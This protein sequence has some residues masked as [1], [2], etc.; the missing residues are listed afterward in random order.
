MSAIVW[1]T[2]T[3]TSSSLA[4][5]LDDEIR[6]S[7]ATI[8]AGLG[9]SFYG[10]GSAA[11]QGASTASSGEL[12]LGTARLPIGAVGKGRSGYSGFLGLDTTSL[13]LYELGD[14]GRASRLL[15]HAQMLHHDDSKGNA[16]FTS[17]WVHNSGSS[18]VAGA[19]VYRAVIN[20]GQSATTGF[21]GNPFVSVALSSAS[22][23]VGIHSVS[24][25]NFTS[26]ASYVG[27][28]VA[29]APVTIY[30]HSE[31]TVAF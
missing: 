2:T 12:L 8:A 6:Q 21:S 22:F 7:M 19:L 31:G 1:N 27:P 24:T 30:W 14:A 20:H 10:P 15:G 18:L 26:V 13:G 16:P 3:P 17:R 28:A 29:N 11:S 4:T 5:S 23:V 25:V 9:T